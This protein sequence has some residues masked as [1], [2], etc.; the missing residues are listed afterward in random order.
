MA[1]PA[2]RW[3]SAYAIRPCPPACDTNASA[4]TADQAFT[5]RGTTCSPLAQAMISSPTAAT[6][7]E[8]AM[9]CATLNSRRSTFTSSR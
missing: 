2:G 8:Y 6:L 5:V 3:A 9:R 4:T 7:L 1:K